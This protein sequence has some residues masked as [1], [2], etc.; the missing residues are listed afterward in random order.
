MMVRI[1]NPSTRRQKQEELEFKA[2]LDYRSRPC[3]K[4]KRGAGER[5]R[6]TDTQGTRETNL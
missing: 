6:Q 2:S 4:K 1:Y 3:L 5:E